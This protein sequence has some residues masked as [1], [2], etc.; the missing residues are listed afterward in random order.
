[1]QSF[2]ERSNSRRLL[3]GDPFARSANFSGRQ[4]R[5]PA[6]AS[7][8][9]RESSVPTSR[10]PTS[11]RGPSPGAGMTACGCVAV[12]C[13]SCYRERNCYQSDE[14]KWYQKRFGGSIYQIH[15]PGLTLVFHGINLVRLESERRHTLLDYLQAHNF[16]RRI[17]PQPET[18]L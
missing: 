15:Q 16:C 1:M 11:G 4:P 9:G 6:S 5:S 2:L 17:L 3:A 12:S 18:K 10:T 8:S 13:K 7:F 14:D